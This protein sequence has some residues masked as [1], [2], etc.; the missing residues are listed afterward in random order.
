MTSRALLL[1]CALGLAALAVQGVSMTSTICEGHRKEDCA[2]HEGCV[3]CRAFSKVDVCME[4]KIAEKLSPSECSWAWAS[5][6]QR[7]ALQQPTSP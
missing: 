7:R 4:I 6:G 5:L 1:L 2:S 3:S